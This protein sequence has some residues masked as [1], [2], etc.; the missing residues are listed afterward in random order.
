MDIISKKFTFQ[1]LLTCFHAVEI[2]AI[3]IDFPV[4]THIAEGLRQIPSGK[5]VG[6]KTLMD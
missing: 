5:G 2:P 6:R 3:G 4:V 1:K